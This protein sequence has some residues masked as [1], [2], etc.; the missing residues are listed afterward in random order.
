[1]DTD[2]KC[3]LSDGRYA[4]AYVDFFEDQIVQHSYDWR[5]MLNEF[6]FEG[7]NPMINGLT[8]G[9]RLPRT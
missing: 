6:L 9:R 4:R 7:E 1:M 2:I 3:L 5:E 8:C